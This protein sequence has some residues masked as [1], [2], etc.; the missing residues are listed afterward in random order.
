MVFPL[1]FGIPALLKAGT[2]ALGAGLGAAGTAGAAGAAAP[3]AAGAGAAGSAAAP[4]ALGTGLGAGA[5]L[6]AAGS[7]LGSTGGALSTAAPIGAGMSVAE[8]FGAAPAF[9]K[10]AGAGG[11]AAGGTAA[12]G[13]AAGGL[14]SLLGG[15]GMEQM[16]LPMLMMGMM[17]GGGPGDLPTGITEDE[18]DISGVKF[19]G[20][21][22]VGPP[23]GFKHGLSGEHNFFP[24][25]E[26][27]GFRRGGRVKRYA[28]GGGVNPLAIQPG[29]NKAPQVQSTPQ[30]PGGV[31][32]LF[33][34]NFSAP[35]VNAGQATKSLTQMPE[36]NIVPF[37]APT[38]PKQDTTGDSN[39]LVQLLY[40]SGKPMTHGDRLAHR[41]KLMT[42]LGIPLSDNKLMRGAQVLFGGGLTGLM[43]PALNRTHIPRRSGSALSV[44]YRH[45]G[46]VKDYAQ[47][48]I[49]ELM[50]PG[51]VDPAEMP[52]TP[53]ADLSADAQ[54]M[55]GSGITPQEASVPQA[56]RAS[57]GDMELVE[58]AVA[59]LQ[60]QLPNPDQILSR[61]VSEFGEQA[62]MDL[63]ARVRGNDP[64]ILGEQNDPD[65][66]DGPGDGASDSVP[67]QMPSGQPAALSDGEFVVP[68]DVVSGLGN[69]STD[70]GAQQLYDMMDR[71]REMRHGG[72][73]RKIDPGKALPK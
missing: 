8:G 60:G 64:D 66:V 57:Q 71:V 52:S 41:E 6:G 51:M 34:S 14:G 56:P 49:A 16:M 40:G 9:A 43:F 42:D 28:K 17:G 63:M 50:G 3:A 2:S 4:A 11:T 12:G 70:A 45:G 39:K 7:T 21:D 19:E 37:E 24:S 53:S 58:A 61:F 48:G 32:G 72:T 35:K 13:T 18:P 5:G 68:S 20:G 31:G 67:A 44:R 26:E 25:D 1:L 27:F 65:L 55:D 47:G 54:G 46:K 36:P 29:Q 15:A 73:V 62:L 33:S 23:S 59:A 30:Q 22:P 38:Q 10:A 69:G